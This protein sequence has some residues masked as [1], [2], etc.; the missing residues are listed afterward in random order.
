MK[1]MFGFYCFEKQDRYKVNARLESLQW[2][3]LRLL[4]I[5]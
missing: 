2:K 1:I 3:N 5:K 4:L